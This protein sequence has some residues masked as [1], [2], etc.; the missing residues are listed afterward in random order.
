MGLVTPEEL[1]H[2]ARPQTRRPVAAADQRW[3]RE[4][5]A[6]VTHDKLFSDWKILVGPEDWMGHAA[7][8]EDVE[9]YR[10]HNLP[11]SNWGPGVYELGLAMPEWTAMNEQRIG[12][13]KKE[14]KLRPQNVMVVYVGNAEHIRQRLQRYGEAG[15]HLED[16]EYFY[17]SSSTEHGVRKSSR[18]PRLFSEVFTLG[19]AIAFRWTATENK[20]AAEK[21]TAELLEVFDYAWNRGGNGPRRSREVIEKTLVARQSPAGLTRSLCHCFRT[22]SRSTWLQP[23]RV[24]RRV[25]VS[26]AARKPT[27]S[28]D[29]P[30][31]AAGSSWS[32]SPC[33]SRR[34][35]AG[36]FWMLLKS[37]AHLL[38]GLG[39]RTAKNCEFTKLDIPIE[40]CGALLDTGLPCNALPVRGRKRCR[41]HKDLKSTRRRGS[42]QQQQQGHATATITGQQIRNYQLGSWLH[43]HSVGSRNTRSAKECLKGTSQHEAA[44]MSHNSRRSDVMEPQ[45]RSFTMSCLPLFLLRA[46][47]MRKHECKTQDVIRSRVSLSFSTWLKT[48]RSGMMTGTEITAVADAATAAA[49]AAAI[50]L[51]TSAATSDHTSNNNMMFSKVELQGLQNEDLFELIVHNIYG[52]STHCHVPPIITHTMMQQNCPSHY[53]IH[54][55]IGI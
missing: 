51:K 25:G 5:C 32:T 17:K 33:F 37:R 14:K 34:M 36:D 4:E 21:A 16:S 45:S 2:V 19:C 7:G 48:S 43:E 42:K 38:P 53:S 27:E 40:R 8:K 47:G 31:E 54:A 3:K 55:E 6:Y 49:A 26:I 41:M 28:R 20:A 23:F 1:A 35:K 46:A 52:S 15:G 10:A 50:K 22:K 18:G 11:G 24:N 44:A 12:L 30:L 13:K 9:K 39:S 29:P